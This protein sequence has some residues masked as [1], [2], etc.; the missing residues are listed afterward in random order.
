MLFR[1]QISLVYTFIYLIMKENATKSRE[2]Q[3]EDE[4]LIKLANIKHIYHH[5]TH[6]Q[7]AYYYIYLDI[8][9]LLVLVAYA[10]V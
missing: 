1:R 7:D 8:F 2:I 6:T 5:H 3:E 4:S 10:I 9:E